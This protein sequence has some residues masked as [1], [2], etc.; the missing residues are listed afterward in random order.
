MVVYFLKTE[1]LTYNFILY[2]ILPAS[3]D[4]RGNIYRQISP[5]GHLNSNVKVTYII[6]N[7]YCIR[8]NVLTWKKYK[9]LKSKPLIYN[10]Q[11]DLVA[12]D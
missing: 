3:Y 8:L 7:V 5:L 2:N 9:Y 12:K 6:Q 10:K 4:L 11:E 1:H